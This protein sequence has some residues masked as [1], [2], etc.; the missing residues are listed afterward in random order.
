MF[1]RRVTW[2]LRTPNRCT[3]LARFSPTSTKTGS[4]P[5]ASWAGLHRRS[6]RNVRGNREGEIPPERSKGK[7]LATAIDFPWRLLCKIPR[8]L[9]GPK[10]GFVENRGSSA[11]VSILCS[12]SSKLQMGVCDDQE[13]S[14]CWSRWQLGLVPGLPG[15]L[16]RQSRIL[17]ISRNLLQLKDAS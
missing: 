17:L 12:N 1:P 8:D 15:E 4:S 11:L 10:H 5:R 13:A 2:F 16:F 9:L 14:R 6:R 3:L 7:S